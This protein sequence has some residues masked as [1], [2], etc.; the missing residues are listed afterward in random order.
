MKVKIGKEY[1]HETGFV[2]VV[3]F[4]DNDN[5]RVETRFG[6]YFICDKSDL[7]EKR[8]ANAKTI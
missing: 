6:S 4:I 8:T 5:V 3:E 1:E 7:R 2:K